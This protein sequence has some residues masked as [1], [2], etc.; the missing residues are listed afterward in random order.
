MLSVEQINEIKQLIATNEEEKAVSLL[1]SLT[2]CDARD[3]R[4]LVAESD[5]EPDFE[6]L[7]DKHW[8]EVNDYGKNQPTEQTV[9]TKADKK[10]L[11]KIFLPITIVII[12]LCV[13]LIYK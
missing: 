2:G 11:L 7:L 8:I 13:Y 1:V 3:A 4:N 5:Y 12:V 9:L 10:N 6:M